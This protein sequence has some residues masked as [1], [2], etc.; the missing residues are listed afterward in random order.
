MVKLL[1][2]PRNERINPPLLHPKQQLIYD[3]PAR[4]QVVDAGRR[5]GKSRVTLAKCADVAVNLGGMVWWVAPNYTISDNQWRLAKKLLGG[6]G[7]SPPIWSDK[8]EV[9]RRL[10]FH[11]PNPDG[12]MSYGEI[13]FKSA[14]K[15]DSLRGEG[16]HFLAIDEAAFMPGDAWVIL[17]PALT[18]NE[19]AAWFIS[20]PAPYLNWFYTLYQYADSEENPDWKAWQFTSY[21]NPFIAK[22]EI[23]ESKKTMLLRD[24][25][26]EHLAQFPEN[27]GQMFANLDVVADV[28]F[29]V[30]RDYS[31][32]YVMGVDWGRKDDYT[33]FSVIELET[34]RQVYAMAFNKTSWAIQK[35]RFKAAYD[36]WQP[37]RCFVEANAAGSPIVE[38]LLALGYKITPFIMSHVSKA[39]LIEALALAF[40]AERLHILNDRSS[41]GKKQLVELR[42]FESTPSAD[43]MK[44][45]Y[46]APKG[47]HDDMVISLA[48]AWAA[49]NDSKPGMTLAE[50]PFY[51][52]ARPGVKRED[53]PP[54]ERPLTML[55]KRKKIAHD[56]QRELLK[57]RGLL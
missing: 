40:E 16:L 25:E 52:E 35:Q 5:F 2:L 26:R 19:G 17:R 11:Y 20:T 9:G 24:F 18:D 46:A 39:P 15:P 56:L 13:H 1:E 8:N 7:G 45:K 10:E 28:P 22:A 21:D 53:V 31:K 42:A 27:Q 57:S 14:D 41:Y 12:T 55:Q 49:A 37:V 30:K 34:K 54:F 4:F 6:G 47:M 36:T 43:G 29:Q 50:N 48:L 33:V 38:E 51:K 44:H 3:D 32:H 23:D